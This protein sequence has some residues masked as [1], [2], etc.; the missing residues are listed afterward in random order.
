[1]PSDLQKQHEVRPGEIVIEI[2][3]EHLVVKEESLADPSEPFNPSK[4]TI[5][6]T[7]DR[8]G[9]SHQYFQPVGERKNGINYIRTRQE[10]IRN[11]RREQRT[12]DPALD[13]VDAIPGERIHLDPVR[14]I[15]RI[16]D[17]IFDP[18]N[19]A[20]YAQL[21]SVSQK[22]RQHFMLMPAVGGYIEVD[23]K[24]DTA[25]WNWCFWMRKIADGDQHHN[26]GPAAHRGCATS[27]PR[28]CRP[29]QNVDQLPTL[30][31][32]SRS[33][34]V[35]LGL[36][37]RGTKEDVE[38]FDT[39]LKSDPDYRPVTGNQVTLTPYLAGMEAASAQ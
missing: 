14:R 32:C 20:I 25:Y 31:E 33:L 19:E 13:R 29:V 34:K 1:M 26:A 7:E 4:V 16:T 36:D 21:V 3:N 38:E 9:N 2:D 17:G 8:A 28:L 27:G 23:L 15:G 37:W 35:K 30:E 24:D 6:R 22:L 39:Y 11:G 5:H 18:E 12:Y 10:L